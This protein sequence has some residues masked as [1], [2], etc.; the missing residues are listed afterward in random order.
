L[1][2]ADIHFDMPFTSLE[3]DNDKSSLRRQELKLVFEKIVNVAKE[4]KVDLM[5]ICGDLYEHGYVRKSTI[6]FI[7]QEFKKISETKVLIIPG[8]HDPYSANSFY[9]NTRWP[10]NVYI[11]TEDN[12]VLELK[13]TGVCVYGCLSGNTSIDPSKINLLLIHGT[14][15]M[16]FN[17]NAFNSISSEKLESYGMDYIA[18]GHFHSKFSGAGM[19][20]S[21]YNPGSPE[22]LGF[23]EEGEHGVFLA[24]IYKREKLDRQIEVRFIPLCMRSYRNIN[25]NLYGCSTDEQ[26][27][28]KVAETITAAGGMEDL[29]RLVLKGTTARDFRID[30]RRVTAC[31]KDKAFFIKVKDESAPDWHFDEIIR[32]PGLRG[33]YVKKMLERAETAKD[34]EEKQMVMQALYFGIQALDQGEVYVY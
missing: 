2:C 12:P 26:V 23:D 3:Y 20:K 32:E 8:N 29:Y 17:K 24:T 28:R 27:I 14:L 31:L 10:D 33:L 25:I 6:E 22:P 30:T 5:L 15:D 34:E 11:L 19:Q 21:I 1:H 7:C 9:S 13:D 4:E 16:N 18:L